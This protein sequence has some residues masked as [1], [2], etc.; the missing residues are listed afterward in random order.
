[1]QGR[2]NSEVRSKGR[3]MLSVSAVCVPLPS[4]VKRHHHH[5][6]SSGSNPVTSGF[7]SEEE[8]CCPV[9]EVLNEATCPLPAKTAWDLE[10]TAA[11]VSEG[12]ALVPLD[13]QRCFAPTLL[14][15]AQLV[16]LE[17]QEPGASCRRARAEPNPQPQ[18]LPRG[19]GAGQHSPIPAA[20]GQNHCWEPVFRN[21]QPHTTPLPSSGLYHNCRKLEQL[22]FLSPS[23]AFDI[24][25][26]QHRH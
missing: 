23:P 13:R 17:E 3:K 11:P 18:G 25:R 16:L 9:H 4:L 10:L 14:P 20:A 12:T 19:K 15:R 24:L 21:Y 22:L 6:H 1:M 7:C 2:C 8:R 26:F 5:A